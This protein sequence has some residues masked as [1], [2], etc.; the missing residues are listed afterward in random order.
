MCLFGDAIIGHMMSSD[1][2]QPLKGIRVIDLADEKAA[3]CSKLL[4]DL[5]AE[6]IKVERPGGDPSRDI[7][8]FADGTPG[9][10]RSLSFWYNNSGKLGLTLDL[11]DREGKQA[12][13][14]LISTADVL[15]ESFAP[16]YLR[17]LGLDFGALSRLNP[18]LIMASVTGFGQTGTLQ[19]L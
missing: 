5:G 18:G 1:A 3:F 14:Q 4:A 15:I 6:V 11:Q 9:P 2:S 8:P 10:E 16:G 19:C 13:L 17:G 7:G 12:L